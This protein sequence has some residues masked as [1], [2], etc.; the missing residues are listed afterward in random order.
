MRHR[1]AEAG[2]R[3]GGDHARRCRIAKD[4]LLDE[5]HAP[6]LGVARHQMLRALKDKVPTQVGL[7]PSHTSSDGSPEKH[8]TVGEV[9]ASRRRIGGTPRRNMP[10]TWRPDKAK[11]KNFAAWE[12]VIH[13]AAS[14]ATQVTMRQVGD[15]WCVERADRYPGGYM[16]RGNDKVKLTPEDLRAVVKMALLREDYPVIECP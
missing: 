5:E 15:S 10:V 16:L 4:G 7:S 8:A 12:A 6:T 13:S 2:G 14:A 3:L 9:G 11:P 1:D